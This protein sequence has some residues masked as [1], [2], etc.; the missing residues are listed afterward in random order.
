MRHPD[1]RLAAAGAA[2]DRAHRRGV[3]RCRADRPGSVAVGTDH[4][5]GRHL[6]RK[7]LPQHP[8]RGIAVET[9]FV[10]Y[11]KLPPL[12]PKRSVLTRCGSWVS[13]T[14]AEATDST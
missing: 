2:D 3:Y 6:E 12:G 1:Q 11:H 13:P 14:S 5:G 4:F 9:L 8:A 7:D 10:T